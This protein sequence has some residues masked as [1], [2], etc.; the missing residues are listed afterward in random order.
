M[1]KSKN[2]N[3]YVPV[4]TMTDMEFE[5]LYARVAKLRDAGFVLTVSEAG[6]GAVRVVAPNGGVQ[7][8]DK[9]VIDAFLDGYASGHAEARMEA[10]QS[11]PV[12]YTVFSTGNLYRLFVDGKEVTDARLPAFSAGAALEVVADR[13]KDG[14]MATVE[15]CCR[16]P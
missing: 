15:F 10:K 7:S 6:G 16:R 13:N 5:T 4:R 8:N 14:G 3:A 1:Q 9:A 11:Q 2:R 12:K